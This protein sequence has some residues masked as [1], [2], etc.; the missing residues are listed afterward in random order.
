LTGL[1]IS[2]NGPFLARRGCPADRR[3]LATERRFSMQ[4]SR[5]MATL[6]DCWRP[7]GR[8]T[9]GRPRQSTPVTV[10]RRVRRAACGGLLKGT[11]SASGWA[12]AVVA[13][14]GPQDLRTRAEEITR[15]AGPGVRPH[16]DRCQDAWQGISDEAR[17]ERTRTGF[18]AYLD[19]SAIPRSTILNLG[20]A[21]SSHAPERPW[22]AGALHRR[23]CHVQLPDHRYWL[24]ISWTTPAASV[25]EHSA[26][27]VGCRKQP[28]H[29]NMD[30][31]D[32]AGAV[33]EWLSSSL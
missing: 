25:S 2:Q 31:D 8:L 5:G 29:A 17:R 6:R 27:V 32:F 20:C 24:W 11:P 23:Q 14:S 1:A 19:L 10:T 21:E 9:K 26:G 18:R 33:D 15:A 13:R 30:W 7:P 12:P 4:P 28:E 3:G 22:R 16:D